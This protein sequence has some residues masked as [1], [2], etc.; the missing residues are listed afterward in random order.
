MGRGKGGECQEEGGGRGECWGIRIACGQ[1]NHRD[2]ILQEFMQTESL[3]S[4]LKQIQ[5]YWPEE[6]VY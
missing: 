2:S 6:S 3:Y 5:Q 1:D 4:F